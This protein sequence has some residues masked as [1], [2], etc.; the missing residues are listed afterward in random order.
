[1]PRVTAPELLDSL[2]ADSPEA[3]RSRA[4]LVRV[5]R[6]MGNLAWF[7]RVLPPLVRPGETCLELGAGDGALALR[8]HAAGLPVDALDLAPQPAGWPPS[9]RWH[10]ADLRD[11]A[12]WAGRPVVLANLF[13][14]HLDDRELAAL[15][16]SLDRHARLLVF[17]EP[18]RSPR[19]LLLWR[20]ASSLGRA[21]PITRH[22]GAV[23]IRAGFRA[24]EL[25]RA[26]GLDPR[27]WSWRVRSTFLGAHRLV[28]ARLP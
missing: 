26:L 10:R 11:F 21:G 2:P 24:A 20:L 5:N 18:L 15:G 3:V 4:D 28:A 16:P 13:L 22:D 27:R 9:A 7:E 23:S 25:P 14:H 8:L 19:C 1:V 6:V 17:N 12:G